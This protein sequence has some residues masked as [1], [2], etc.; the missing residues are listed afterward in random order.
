MN[1]I[2][3]LVVFALGC[4]A[5]APVANEPTGNEIAEEATDDAA[6]PRQVDAAAVARGAG[7]EPTVGDDGV[8]KVTWARTD[9]QI[10]VDGSAFP[11]AAGL[12][13]WAAF[14]GTATGA[15]LMGDTVVF[16]DEAGAAMDAAF[17][18]GLEVSAIHNHFFFDRPPVY[19]MH[20]GGMGDAEQ[21]A[22]GVRAVWD[23]IRAVRAETPQPSDD[24]GG[25]AAIAEGTLDASALGDALDAEPAVAGGVVKFT[26]AREG[27]MHG[28]RIGGGMGLTTWTAFVGSDGAA[29]VD[30]D[31]IMTAEEVQPVLRALRQ[32]GF[33]VVALHNHMI[34]G[35]PFFYFTHYWGTGPAIELARGLAAVREAQDIA[36]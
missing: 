15:M 3:A 12:T 22:V 33:H 29:S 28:V 27:A 16:E 2:L 24:F 26:W 5:T 8:V 36:P 4:G 6:D 1:R 31:F 25:D 18:H 35:E 14:T 34:G 20:I 11:A 13:S 19:F 30:G 7:V 9:V 21:L 32:H 23:A 17:A 10:T